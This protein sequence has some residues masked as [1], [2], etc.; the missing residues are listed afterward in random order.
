M[1]RR[2]HSG[3]RTARPAL[4][5]AAP[6]KEPRL[7]AVIPPH[8]VN[9][10]ALARHIADQ[11][12]EK[13]AEEIV[14]LDIHAVAGFADYFVIASASSARQLRALGDAVDEAAEPQQARRE[15]TAD[16]GWQVFDFGNVIVHIFSD[17]M[18]AFYD[19]EGRWSRGRQLLRIE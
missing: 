14:L 7:N 19:L 13:Q 6:R 9:D 18:R 4:G 8:T 17:E 3:A 1:R 5:A 11:L 12:A 10:E 2:A 15:G 16:S